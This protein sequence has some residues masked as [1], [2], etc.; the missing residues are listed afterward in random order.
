[1]IV[2]L[3]A[4]WAKKS[5]EEEV[6]YK[7]RKVSLRTRI[8]SSFKTCL[9]GTRTHR[10]APDTYS[11]NEREIASDDDIEMAYGATKAGKFVVDDGILDQGK[12]KSK[13][14]M[15]KAELIDN[16]SRVLFP[17]IFALYNLY[18]WIHYSY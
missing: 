11:P 1:M 4:K 9:F 14:I 2:F 12:M 8:C 5:E 7:K 16:A 13:R 6:K 18:Y 3:V 10:R 17:L 15:K